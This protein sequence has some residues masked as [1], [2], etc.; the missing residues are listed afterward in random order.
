[1]PITVCSSFETHSMVFR[2]RMIEVIPHVSRGIPVTHLDGTT[3]IASEAS[4]SEEFRFEVL[5]VFKGNPGHEITVTGGTG[6]FR[7]GEQYLIFASFNPSEKRVHAV[8]C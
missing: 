2:G 3:E 1:M 5:E 6:E 4:M 8:P 7:K